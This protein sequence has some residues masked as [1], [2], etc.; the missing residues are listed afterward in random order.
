MRLYTYKR[1]LG[2]DSMAALDHMSAEGEVK[3]NIFTPVR[4]FYMDSWP[5]GLVG[6]LDLWSWV[7]LPQCVTFLMS[8]SA[9]A[10]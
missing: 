7:R 2:C 5:N 3:P 1:K 10:L 6:M 9:R 8:C 4:R